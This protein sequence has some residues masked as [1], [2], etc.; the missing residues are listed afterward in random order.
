VL[1]SAELTTLAETQALTF[2]STGTIRRP[3]GSTSDGAGGT[4]AT[5]P[6]STANVSCRIAPALVSDREMIVAAGIQA[7]TVWRIT[8]PRGTD[9]RAT[10]RFEVGSRTFE[11]RAV[12]GARTFETARVT[13]AVER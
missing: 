4:V 12:Y 1:T 2:D 9:I 11:I 3:A 8:V 10:D 6:T 13:L 7:M 5:N